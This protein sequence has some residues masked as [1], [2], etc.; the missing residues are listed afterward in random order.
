MTLQKSLTKIATATVTGVLAGTLALGSTGTAF[1]DDAPQGNAP[2]VTAPDVSAPD[3]LQDDDGL[4]P[5]F[6]TSGLDPVQSDEVDGTNAADAQ[7]PDLSAAMGAMSVTSGDSG[8][9]R[10]DGRGNGRGNG[11]DDNRG[12]GRENG[13]GDHR[14]NGRG[15]NS[16]F[17]HRSFYKGRVTARVGLRVRSAPSTH[18]RVLGTLSHGS[19][20]WIQ[21]KVNSQVVDGNPRW[22]KLAKGMWAWSAARYISNVGPAPRYCHFREREDNHSNNNHHWNNNNSNNNGHNS[23]DNNSSWNHDGGNNNNWSH[24]DS[25]GKG[26]ESHSNQSSH[27]QD[28]NSSNSWTSAEGGN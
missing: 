6:D 23:H 21:C 22:Y 15:D 11:R 26:T 5:D 19:L 2:E 9:H 3:L 18:A 24:K 1:A 14:G 8:D 20:V 7:L 4:E 28:W 16:G 27:N 10:G 13:R 17:P 12:D 25:N